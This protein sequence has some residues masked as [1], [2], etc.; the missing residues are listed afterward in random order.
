VIGSGLALIAGP[1][2][3]H[4]VRAG[5]ASALAGASSPRRATLVAT[6]AD[7]ADVQAAL[8]TTGTAI[9]PDAALLALGR[10]H[11]AGESRALADGIL[12]ADALRQIPALGGA[13]TSRPHP[14]VDHRSA[15]RV[16]EGNDDLDVE[17]PSGPAT[18]AWVTTAAQR[19]ALAGVLTHHTDRV[20]AV[21]G[22]ASL[23]SVPGTRKLTELGAGG[24]RFGIRFVIRHGE[25]TFSD[26][27]TGLALA[28]SLDNADEGVPGGLLAGDVA[29]SW[30]VHLTSWHDGV[31]R[32][33]SAS[34]DYRHVVY[35]RAL[36]GGL[37]IVGE[38][39][40]Q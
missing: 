27:L 29:V 40:E 3:V 22:I 37:A 33:A 13:V 4:A 24:V 17:T 39:R 12:L 11:D 8:T 16:P 28:D 25:D 6:A 34:S 1:P 14:Q 10:R 15:G 36:A 26:A 7:V 31:E 2:L 18:A 9:T 38:G 23:A 21:V 19:A 20:D 32:P 35:L 30:P 5:L